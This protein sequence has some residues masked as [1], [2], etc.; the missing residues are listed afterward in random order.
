M[1]AI[2][3]V[4]G[5]IGVF[6]LFFGAGIAL[7]VYWSAPHWARFM[8]LVGS[9]IPGVI[10]VNLLRGKAREMFWLSERKTR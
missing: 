1:K 4:L 10:V 7:F 9:P 5:L 8:V 3:R 2:F 6:L